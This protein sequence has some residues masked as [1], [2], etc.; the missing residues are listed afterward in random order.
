MSLYFSHLKLGLLTQFPALNEDNFIWIKVPSECVCGDYGIIV[1]F[2]LSVVNE[3]RRFLGQFSTNFHLSCNFTHTMFH[4]CRD[5]PE[6]LAKYL[7]R[8]DHLTCSK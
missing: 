1:G 8:L 3:F 7:R 5:H 6:N 4:S 2:T